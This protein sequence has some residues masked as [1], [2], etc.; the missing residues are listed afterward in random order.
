VSFKKREFEKAAY[1]FA[2]A[3][4]YDK[5]AAKYHFYY[6]RALGEVGKYKDALEALNKALALKPSDPDTLAETGHIYLKLGFPL[7][8]T[9]YFKQV[10]EKNPSHAKA[11]EGMRLVKTL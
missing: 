2:S 6:G 3:L 8:A 9:G 4:Y 11:A 1:A 5:S 10:L 7:R